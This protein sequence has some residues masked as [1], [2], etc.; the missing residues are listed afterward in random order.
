[1]RVEAERQNVSWARPKRRCWSCA[2]FVGRVKST[3]R[4]RR[5]RRL[6]RSAAAVSTAPPLRA[7]AT[8]ASTWSLDSISLMPTPPISRRERSR[9]GVNLRVLRGRVAYSL[10]QH[11]LLAARFLDGHGAVPDVDADRAPGAAAGRGRAHL[12][13]GA[14]ERLARRALVAST[15]V[16]G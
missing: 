3:S 12:Q 7:A 5:G 4:T 6:A 11:L 13:V 2:N 1:M 15:D 16:E 10:R 8:S 14:L 9:R